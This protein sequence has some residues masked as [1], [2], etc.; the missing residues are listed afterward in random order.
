MKDYLILM[1]VFAKENFSLKRMLGSSASKS[2]AKMAFVVLAILYLMVVF[3]GGFGWMFFELG[4]MLQMANMT[5][6]LL[7]YLFTYAT[8][9]SLLLGL[10]RSDGYFFHF[11]DYDQ[12]AP[13][14]LSSKSVIAAKATVMLA[15]LYL[16]TII[17][18][19]PILFSYFYYTSVSFFQVIMI[20]LGY[21][22]IPFPAVV[23]G[24]ALNMIIMRVTVRLK[25]SNLIKIVLMFV[26][27]IGI[28]IGSFTM[29]FQSSNPL[30]GQLDFI[31]SLGEFYLPM[32]WFLEAGHEQNV[33]SFL[34]LLL[35]HVGLLVGFVLVIS[36]ASMHLNSI[37]GV[38]KN[39]SKGNAV[40]HTRGIF[41]SLLIKETRTYFGMTMY[42]FNTFFGPIFM[43]ILSVASI[44]YKD[45]VLSFVSQEFGFELPLI[46]MI[47]VIIG[48]CLAMVYTTAISLSIEGKKFSFLRS[49][50]IEP[51]TIMESKLVF[52]M[53]LGLPIAIIATI[54]FSITFSISFELVLLM[55]LVLA[56]FSFL[57]SAFG[58]IINLYMPKFDFINEVEVIKQSLGA[59][60]AIFGGFGWL[61]LNGVIYYFVTKESSVGLALV[62]MSLA[63]L[64]IGSGFFVWMRQKSESLFMKMIA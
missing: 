43:L 34:W 7:L 8:A 49:L 3:I 32:Q 15:N 54:I 39:E 64:V 2:K 38:A 17:V 52:N 4:K 21:L 16:I 22:V 62:L 18:S 53:L 26:I 1:R 47:L 57:N 28:M 6:L 44:I 12:L 36:K 14:P 10:L 30:E 61:A 60:I 51:R 27:F 35:S 56:T 19:L 46:P 25:K 13:L 33:L 59:L 48:F 58:S 41:Q 11:K 31:R 63:N 29:N 37:H 45:K 23:L 42:V 9:F 20:I 40:S 5:E 55:I 50:P 24:A